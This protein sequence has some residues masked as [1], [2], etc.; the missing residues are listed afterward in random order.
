MPCHP[1]YRPSAQVDSRYE[2]RSGRQGADD[3]IELASISLMR[4]DERH[5]SRRVASIGRFRDCLTSPRIFPAA[6][7][8]P[9]ASC[10]ASC[11][12]LPVLSGIRPRPTAASRPMTR[13]RRRSATPAPRRRHPPSIGHAP[14]R[15]RARHVLLAVVLGSAVA[16]GSVASLATAAEPPA[17]P[18]SNEPTARV[19]LPAVWLAAADASSSKDALFG[20][21]VTPAP[22]NGAK[23]DSAAPSKDALFGNDLGLAPKSPWRGSLLGELA[24]TYASPSHWS[25]MLASGEVSAEG[26]LS[27]SVKYKLFARFDYDFVYDA[28]DFYPPDVP[29]DQRANFMLRENYLDV[30]AGDWDF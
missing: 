10:P 8:R 11:I 28:N 30:G 3:S 23:A 24:R 21:D 5:A 17:D 16:L 20:S 6:S 25:K 7:W 26:P 15:G 13:D 12:K 18:S 4:P 2:S 14:R 9:S 22:K 29:H 27:D 1:T 19:G